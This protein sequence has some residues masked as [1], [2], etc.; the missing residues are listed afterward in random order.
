MNKR[1]KK[2][3]AVSVAGIMILGLAACGS[4]KDGE[5]ADE[6]KLVFAIWDKGQQSG[7]EALADAYME[8]HPNVTIEVQ[9]SG[10]D[11]YWTKLEASATSDS[12][13]DVFWMHSNQIYKYADNGLLADCSDIINADDFSDIS[14]QNATGSDGKVYGVP[15]DKDIIAL[16]YNKELFDEAGVAYPDENWTWDDM[17]DASEKIYDATGKYGY[18][19]YSHDQIGYWN[20]VYQ[21]GGRILNDDGTEAEFTEPATAEAMKYY[22]ELQQNDWCPTQE[23]FVNTG[24]SEMFFSGEGAMFYTGNWDLANLC[25]SYPEMN[26]KWDVTVLPKCPDPVS[27]D[28]RASITNSVSYATF[29][30]GKN[31]DLAMDFLAFL[32]SEEGQRIQ[33][34]SGA[35]IPAYNGLED[36]WIKTFENQGYE[37]NVES[38]MSM[39]DYSVKYVNNP[40]RPVWEPKVTQ[41]MLDIYAGNVS[42]D[43]GIQN[44]QKIV[45]EAIEEE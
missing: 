4:N 20:F 44:I 14:V 34:E 16:A 5:T 41:A 28:G 1:I 22:I 6:G 12:G 25:K 36:T 18:M 7:M 19:A 37:L 11:E 32:G 35:G 39:F 21:N 31:K 29:E 33:G 17:E 45:T 42:V 10:W 38:L 43:E 23:Q 2:G 26:G 13:P 30:N 24:A 40:S 27:G 8:E 15:K 9:A 3:F